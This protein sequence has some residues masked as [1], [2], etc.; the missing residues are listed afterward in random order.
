MYRRLVLLLAAIT[1]TLPS[2]AHAQLATM[3]VND[4]VFIQQQ[5]MQLK[6]DQAKLNVQWAQ[7][8][9][10]GLS[11]VTIR[12]ILW[13]A[14]VS[15]YNAYLTIV[16]EERDFVQKNIEELQAFHNDAAGYK[17]IVRPSDWIA[18]FNNTQAAGKAV[19]QQVGIVTTQS[20][21]GAVQ[22]KVSEVNLASAIG[23]K[24]AIQGLGALVG[25]QTEQVAKATALAAAEDQAQE[26][27]REGQTALANQKEQQAQGNSAVTT[28]LT[29]ATPAPQ[30]PPAPQPSSRP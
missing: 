16:N 26:A 28:W 29:G 10:Q 17:G 15:D 30:S 14:I 25:Q 13:P 4:P 18:W 2:V 8:K 1:L 9:A 22:T 6:A 20:K 3:D 11:I 5:T 12:K 21:A 23:T 7:L 19:L 27:Y 24:A